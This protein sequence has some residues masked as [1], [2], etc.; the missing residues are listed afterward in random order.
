[1]AGR[2]MVQDTGVEHFC[3]SFEVLSWSSVP[4][5]GFL[6]SACMAF[7]VSLCLGVLL[8]LDHSGHT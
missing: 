4:A 3:R 6:H 7:G 1:M 8:F 5:F 2:L